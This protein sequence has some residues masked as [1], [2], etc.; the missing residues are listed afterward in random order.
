MVTGKIWM[1]GN[2]LARLGSEEVETPFARSILV[3]FDSGEEEGD[4]ERV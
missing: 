3:Q 4:A 2:V 1:A